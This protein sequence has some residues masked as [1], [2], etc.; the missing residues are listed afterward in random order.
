[1]LKLP[2]ILDIP[3]LGTDYVEQ[4]VLIKDTYNSFSYLY[5]L[6]NDETT[7]PTLFDHLDLILSIGDLLTNRLT[8]KFSI[9]DDREVMLHLVVDYTQLIFD[10]REEQRQE[11][12]I[13]G[14]FDHSLAVDSVIREE[15]MSG[16]MT[17]KTLTD[18]EL[19]RK[20]TG[21]FKDFT[22]IAEAAGGNQIIVKI[23]SLVKM[24]S[25]ECY[26]RYMGLLS[27]AEKKPVQSS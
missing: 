18:N 20:M 15:E 25:V 13:E 8:G 27:L 10:I 11:I 4:D 2:P 17:R 5:G 16:N 12:I 9:P 26:D 3:L 22:D 6:G 7:V 24:V 21:L 19:D 23:N 1:M 14:D